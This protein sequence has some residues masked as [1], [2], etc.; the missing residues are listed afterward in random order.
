[1]ELNQEGFYFLLPIGLLQFMNE[2]LWDL[3][4]IEVE[5]QK[6]SLI[7]VLNKLLSKEF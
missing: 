7:S 6:C 4:T 3:I 1:M 5:T 2:I